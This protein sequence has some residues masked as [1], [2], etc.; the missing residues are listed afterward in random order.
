MFS[1]VIP[2]YNKA[3]YIQRCIDSVVNQTHKEFEII[4]VDDGAT[5]NGLQFLNTEKVVNITIIHQQN[6]GVS[7]TRNVGIKNAKYPY[8][9]FLDADDCWHHDYLKKVKEVINKEKKIKIIG[10]HYSRN[11]TF[12]S[13]PSTDLNYFKFEDYF[14]IAIKNTYFTSSSTVIASEFFNADNGFNSLLKTG[15][16]IDVWF[17]AVQSGGNAFYIKNTLVYYSDEDENQ[18]TKSKQALS[19]SLVGNINSLYQNLM[20]ENDAD[21][22][23]TFVSK[24]VYFNLYPI[25]FDEDYRK[26]AKIIVKQNRHFFFWM[27]LVYILPFS[28]GTKSVRLYLKFINRFIH[29]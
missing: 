25:Y 20:K 3:K 2:Y 13:K 17:R 11:S 12:L 29:T 28:I 18:T 1:I 26:E 14:K 8:I 9:A 22:F 24:Y 5:D 4:L 21:S 10:S 15:E 27:H 7:E 6:K 23:N 19:N 16:D